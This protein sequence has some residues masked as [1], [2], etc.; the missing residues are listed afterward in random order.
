MKKNSCWYSRNVETNKQKTTATTGE[1][2]VLDSRMSL[3]NSRTKGEKNSNI[4]SQ[5]NSNCRYFAA[6]EKSLCLFVTLLSCWSWS[7]M[8]QQS[9]GELLCTVIYLKV[10]PK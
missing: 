5:A 1:T 9:S 2:A 10:M 6:Y 8:E 7:K 4:E 3:R